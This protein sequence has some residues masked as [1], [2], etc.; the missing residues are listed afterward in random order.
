MAYAQEWQG[1]LANLDATDPLQAGSSENFISFH[2]GDLGFIMERRH[3]YAAIYRHQSTDPSLAEN[4]FSVPYIHEVLNFEN[5]KVVMFNLDELLTELFHLDD[6]DTIKVAI[7]A[8]LGIF[9]GEHSSIVA[10]LLE[11]GYEGCAGDALA[12]RISSDGGIR[13]IALSELRVLPAGLR[14]FL[15]ARGIVACRVSEDGMEYVIDPAVLAMPSLSS[16][17]AEVQS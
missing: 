16:P 7:I 11:K 17:I 4:A 2:L 10:G 15:A 14:S 8:G 3:F 6:D 13:G 9:G 1:I 12:F 5:R